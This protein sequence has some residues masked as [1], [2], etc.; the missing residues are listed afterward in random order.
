MWHFSFIHTSYNIN[1]TVILI[2]LLLL[3]VCMFV[4]LSPPPL[5]SEMVSIGDFC[6]MQVNPRT[7]K[8]KENC[9]SN[10]LA[11]DKLRGHASQHVFQDL[12]TH[13]SAP[14]YSPLIT[15]GLANSVLP[16][17]TPHSQPC[18]VQRP[19]IVYMLCALCMC[20]VQWLINVILPPPPS[21]S[22][23]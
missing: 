5:D 9:A 15:I 12:Y 20:C 11:N 6:P 8:L 14:A 21:K 16:A 1:K 10:V 19:C 17:F 4:T 23:K 18:I 3:S 13:C 7:T 22:V 2:L